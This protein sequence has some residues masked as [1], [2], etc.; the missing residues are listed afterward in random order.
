MSFAYGSS[1][2]RDTWGFECRR[3]RS[4]TGAGAVC[5]PADQGAM[6]V[7]MCRSIASSSRFWRGS[8]KVTA[9]PERPTRP[10]RPIRCT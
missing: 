7:P 2:L 5:A 8:T 10:V 1:P 4:E 9:R 3:G 6:S